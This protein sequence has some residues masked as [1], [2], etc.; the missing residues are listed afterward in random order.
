MDETDSGCTLFEHG[1]HVIFETSGETSGTEVDAV[2]CIVNG[3]QQAVDVC[4]VAENAGQSEDGVGGIVGVDV[5]GA[6]GFEGD[7][8]YFGEEVSEVVFEHFAGQSL[9]FCEHGFDLI[10]SDTFEA[11]EVINDVGGEGFAF[12]FGHIVIKDF[13]FGDFFC[14]II[15][16]CTFAFKDEEFKGGELS[17]IEIQ[18]F[19]TVGEFVTQIGTNPVENGHEVVN[20]S[21]Y[22][23]FAEVAE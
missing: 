15:F 1:E 17:L 9:V 11:G 2:G 3:S 13:G 21:F 6:S 23:A 22:A 5:E 18:C 20:N 7:R 16:F 19:R 14:G 4:T 8:S 12:I 10:E